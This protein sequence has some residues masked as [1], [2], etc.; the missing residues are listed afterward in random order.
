M[1][2]FAPF[3][4][5]GYKLSH[6]SMY[7]DGTTLVNA[8]NTP[9]SDRHYRK[10]ATRFYR[11]KLTIVG[12]QGAFMET[13]ADWDKF[14]AMDK[15]VAIAQFKM[16]CDFYTG[17]DSVPVEPLSKLHD[18][19]YLPLEIR[20]L[21]EGTEVNFGIPVFTI[22]NTVD[23]A[24]WLVNFLETVLSNRTWKGSTV[25]TIAREYR[26]MLLDFA[27]RT[28]S[29]LEL[30]DLQ[31]HSFACRGMSGPED[32][33][34]AEFGHI[35][36]HLGTDSLGSIVYAMKYYGETG[37]VAASVPATEHAV[38][39]SNILLIESQL[40]EGS[41]VPRNQEQSN[42]L[43]EMY[44]QS[45][46]T[47]F[48]A[49]IMFAYDLMTRK[50][51]TGILS[52]VMDSFDF[53]TVISR[54]LVYL[55]DV[56]MKRETNGITPGKLVCRPDSG[57]PVQVICGMKP[58]AGE[59]GKAIDF[60]SVAVFED[61]VVS[62]GLD[63]VEG[64]D[65]VK[66]DGEFYSVEVIRKIGLASFGLAIGEEEIP[67][68]VVAG[69]I[70]TLWKTFGGTITETGHKLLDSHIGLIYGDSITPAR[71]LEI[72]ERLEAAGFAS[73][74]VVFGV[75]SF[76]YQHVTRDT[77]G[78]AVKA[79]Y[80]EVEVDGVTREV[81]IF[82][83]PKT[84]SKKNSAKG[85]LYVGKDN[86]YFLVDNVSKEVYNSDNNELKVRFRNGAWYNLTTL[87]EIRAKIRG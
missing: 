5:D 84:D 59:D 45:E 41:F 19:G 9:R 47:R 13:V 42:I 33:A 30:V 66:I 46:E 44:E 31:A 52:Y 74:N 28:G 36:S 80:T 1:D 71:C 76:T 20:S 72:L 58:V 50:F 40:S 26:D 34:R 37:F 51:P 15:A 69:A 77:F 64:F 65:C 73:A 6:A 38:A 62:N 81:P 53:W 55:K 23:H 70:R 85:L 43:I 83:M 39:T 21:D 14:F 2:L 27:I 35:A 75:G 25:A 49:E 67:Y 48:I 11:K 63:G 54:G 18:I 79:T 3:N 10:Q 87:G 57:D 8:N 24:F 86:D 32:S 78:Y 56:I 61:F 68:E 82:K 4:S 16:L 29:P 60:E 22:Q 17:P 7:A 12:L